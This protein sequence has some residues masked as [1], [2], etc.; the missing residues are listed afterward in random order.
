[1]L[2]ATDLSIY[3]ETHFIIEDFSDSIQKDAQ[4]N[5][6]IIEELFDEFTVV[7]PSP[8]ERAAAY[9]IYR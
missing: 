4:E 3:P 5:P 8:E 7:Q 9:E 2:T 6:T 1:M